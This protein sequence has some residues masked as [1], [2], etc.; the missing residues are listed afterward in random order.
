MTGLNT[1]EAFYLHKRVHHGIKGTILH[2]KKGYGIFFV[3][4]SA[5][6]CPEHGATKKG[7]SLPGNHF[8]NNIFNYPTIK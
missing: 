4:S 5:V 7:G 1:F 3:I 6:F 2:F 8:Y